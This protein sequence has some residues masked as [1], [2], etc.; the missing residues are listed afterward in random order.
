MKS[1]VLLLTTCS[2]LVSSIPPPHPDVLAVRQEEERLPPILRS[3]ALR[4]PHLLQVLPLTSLLHKGEKLVYARDAHD[5]PRKEIHKILTHAGLIPRKTFPS[6]AE[7]SHR[8]N[9]I[10]I[11]IPEKWSE[12]EFSDSLLWVALVILSWYGSIIL[13]ISSW[14]AFVESP[15]SFGVE[16]TY[17]NWETKM[18]SVAI[19][20]SIYM[21]NVFEVAD[22]IWPPLHLLDLEDALKEIAYFR[23][24]AY[25]LVSTCFTNP[26]PDPL[27]PTSNYSYYANLIRRDCNKILKNCSYNN[28]EFSCCEYFQPIETDVGPCYILNSIQTKNP[29]PYPMVNNLQNLKGV[30]KFDAH[31][32]VMMY[33]L[34]EDEV[35]TITTLHS[36]TFDLGIGYSYRRILSVRN[37]ENDPLITETTPEQRACRFHHENEGGLYPHYSYSACTVLCRK[38]AQLES[39]HCNDH[40]MLGTTEETL[41]NLTGMACLNKLQSHLTTLKP[42][43]AKRPGL[44]C[45][46]LPSCDE[47]EIT[48]IKDVT[49]SVKG[50]AN[51]K[52]AHVEIVLAYLPTERFKRNVVRSRLDL[53]VSVGGTTG[54]FVG[55]SLLSFVELF[56]FF[57][58]RFISNIWMERKRNKEL[59]TTKSA[60]VLLELPGPPE[61]EEFGPQSN[62][63]RKEAYTSSGVPKFSPKLNKHIIK[64][65]QLD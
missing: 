31:F 27:C 3:P 48:V 49:S 57:T 61:I 8:F 35:P 4:N 22:A 59:T 14:N 5:V 28:K 45:N 26:D 32:P 30:L 12:G 65:K 23:G 36:S 63:S 42:A 21:D 9:H 51:K 11:S 54:L 44:S 34:G 62:G 56:F 40:F 43:W 38:K 10:P 60:L 15:I 24:V 64:L 58:V 16:T 19:C 47:T 29:R 53:V 52:K 55:A 2:C 39:C 13:I 33:T 7:Y 50:K 1:L 20:E 25:V 18:P 37:I 41:C 17:T 6:P 46:C